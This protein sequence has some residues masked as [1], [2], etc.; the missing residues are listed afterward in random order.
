MTKGHNERLSSLLDNELSEKETISLIKEF[1]NNKGLH[2][3]LDRY[4][5]IRDAIHDVPQIGDEVFLKNIQ[6]K[7]V[8]GPTILA[9][10]HKNSIIKTPVALA[11][12]ASVAFLTVLIFDA[13]L[14]KS[15]VS[16]PYSPS[17][18]APYSIVSSEDEQKERLALEEEIDEEVIETNTVLL[19]QQVTFEK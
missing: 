7:L 19:P 12:A 1:E 10:D 11:L 15:S 9:P 2:D 16:E 4:A 14:F 8:A 13:D 3:K 5:L 17:V 6:E 18:S